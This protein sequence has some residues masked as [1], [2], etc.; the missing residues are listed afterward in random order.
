MPI[1]TLITLQLLPI[2]TLSSQK[3]TRTVNADHLPLLH[4]IY[5][6]HTHLHCC[7]FYWVVD[8]SCFLA[9]FDSWTVSC[10]MIL[11]LL[12][13][14]C[15]LD[16][17]CRLPLMVLLC[18]CFDPCLLTLHY[19]KA[20]FGASPLLPHHHHYIHQAP[21]ISSPSQTICIA[22]FVVILSLYFN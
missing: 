12:P 6:Y 1:R 10:C 20:A 16:Y 4:T 5:K 15:S 3:H 9:C 21:L 2:E 17:S 8:V 13:R 7:V 18:S 14:P 22:A 11:C 19:N